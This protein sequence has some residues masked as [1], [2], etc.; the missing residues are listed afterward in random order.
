MPAILIPPK[1]D[2]RSLPV[3]PFMQQAVPGGIRQ[4][5]HAQLSAQAKP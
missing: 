4:P 3:G 2:A 1:Q 5:T